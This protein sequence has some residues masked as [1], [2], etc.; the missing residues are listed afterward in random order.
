MDKIYYNLK[1]LRVFHICKS[2]EVSTKRVARF[3]LVFWSGCTI[4]ISVNIWVLASQKHQPVTHL[5]T[6]ILPALLLL[7]I[8]KRNSNAGGLAAMTRCRIYRI[9]PLGVDC[10]HL[11]VLIPCLSIDHFFFHLRLTVLSELLRNIISESSPVGH[12]WILLACGGSRFNHLCLHFKKKT[13]PFV[14]MIQYLNTHLH[15][16][17][18]AVCLNIALYFPTSRFMGV[19]FQSTCFWNPFFVAWSL[20]LQQVCL[21]VLVGA[22]V[23]ILRYK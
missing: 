21:I 18:H 20:Y 22:H 16:F 1:Y 5:K 10:K 14:V 23:Q 12:P 2:E 15:H 3:L 8:L 4:G 19:H 6:S 13:F 7:S 9:N 11:H 17:H